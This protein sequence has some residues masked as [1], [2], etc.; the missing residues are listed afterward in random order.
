VE[1]KSLEARSIFDRSDASQ[2]SAMCVRRLGS[3]L[4]AATRGGV[5]MGETDG[6]SWSK[7]QGPWQGDGV[8][9]FEATG[10]N[11]F[12]ASG[13]GVFKT[14]DNGRTWAKVFDVGSG[15]EVPEAGE[16]DVIETSSTARILSMTSG[17]SIVFIAT[18][19]GVKQTTDAGATWQDAP[20]AGCDVVSTRRLYFDTPTQRLYALTG[21]GVYALKADGWER[22]MSTGFARDIFR[23][24]E[25]ISVLTERGI[26]DLEVVLEAGSAEAPENAIKESTA[27]RFAN[28]PTVQEVQAMAIAYAEVDNNKI[29]DWRR[30]ANVKALMPTLGMNYSKTIYG[31]SSGAIAV[32]P[33]DWGMTMSWDLG[34]LIYNS[35]QT[36][37]DTRSKL[38]VELRNDI[39]AEVTRLYFERRKL[40]I[41][42]MGLGNVPSRS[43]K[44]LKFQET[45]ALMDRLTGGRY[46]RVLKS[47]PALRPN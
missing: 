11:L 37:I 18:S 38:M 12:A 6:K 21:S 43:D 40:Q 42:V 27:D 23:R 30:R 24:G 17:S 16:T 31:S 41:E 39:L 26:R 14:S 28:E 47:M 1:W 7:V 35:D 15:I 10:N 29:K 22:C 25:R 32:G 44:E 9:F 34:D 8:V 13:T 36:S 5:F 46:S 2:R 19:S 3:S 33:L 20:S 4:F 45:T